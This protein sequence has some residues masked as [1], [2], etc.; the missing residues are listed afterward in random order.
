M[1]QASKDEGAYQ[2]LWRISRSASQGSKWERQAGKDNGTLLKEESKMVRSDT[3]K[4]LRQL[5]GGWIVGGGRFESTPAVSA[6][7]A[8]A[9]FSPLPS[10]S[11]GECPLPRS[12]AQWAQDSDLTRQPLLS[13]WPQGLA[14]E[15]AASQ[16]SELQFWVWFCL[17]L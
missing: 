11:P 6:P 13:P 15:G 2:V 17:L 9:L 12:Q 8:T 3:K 7:P 1:T 14:Q 5:S 16:A 10:P 4:A